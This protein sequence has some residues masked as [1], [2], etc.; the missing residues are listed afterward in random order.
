MVKELAKVPRQP[1]HD[2]RNNDMSLRYL[3]GILLLLPLAAVGREPTSFPQAKVALKS[4]QQFSGLV[5]S[6]TPSE[7]EFAEIVRPALSALRQRSHNAV[8]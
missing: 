4:G 8:E 7:L 2:S 5:L 6:E 3:L 1:S